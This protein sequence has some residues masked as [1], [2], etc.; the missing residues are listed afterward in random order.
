[1]K[2]E[3][4]IHSNWWRIPWEDLAWVSCGR[5]ENCSIGFSVAKLK[6]LCDEELSAIKYKNSMVATYK[7]AKVYLFKFNRDVF[8]STR[9]FLLDLLQLRNINCNNLTKFIGLTEGP[10]GLY[11]MNEYCTRGDLR[12]ILGNE[13]FTLNWDVR[14]SLTCDVIQAMDYIHGSNLK[15]HGHLTSLNC[16]IDSRFVLKVTEFGIQSLR[17][18]DID[19][20]NKEIIRKLTEIDE[21][22]FRPRLDVADVDKDMVNLMK[23]CW[24]ENP[25]TR[26]SFSTIKKEASRLDWDKTGDKFLD[27]LLSRMEEYAN[28]LEDLVD[29]RTQAFLEEKKRSEELLYQVL[30]RSVADELRNGRMVDPEAFGCVTIYFSDIVG[31]TSISSESTPMQV[32]DLLNDLYTCFDKII[33]HF[34]VYKV[35]TIGDAYMVVSGLPV[36]NGDRHVVEIAKMSTAILDN[37]KIFKIRHRPDVK[38]RARI[39][40]HSGPVCAGVVGRKMPRYCLFGDTVNTASRM[41]SNGEAMKIH[42]SESTRNLLLDN[43]DFDLEQREEISVKG[44]GVMKTYWLNCRD[45]LRLN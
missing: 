16:V 3:S 21:T 5:S 35:E 11:A 7:G 39:G 12:D 24:N 43:E 32:V 27:N 4:E 14:A 34:D 1:M 13:S 10:S 41:E 29:E 22:P 31:F 9:E 20:T 15:Y 18:F 2:S 38:L 30:P 19:V 40:L 17:D 42:V 36:R 26:P 33:D 23:S 25:K 8:P 28:N 45:E 6:S 44:K 37:V